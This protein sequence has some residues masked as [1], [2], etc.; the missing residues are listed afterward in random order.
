ML[1]HC[2]EVQDVA[3]GKP[4]VGTPWFV[5]LLAPFIRRTVVS[6]NPYPKGLRTHPQYVQAAV[7][8]FETERARLLVALEGFRAARHSPG[9]HPLFGDMTEA[10]RGWASYKH[11]DH[12][13]RQFGV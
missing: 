1:A 6:E 13:L 11:L 5:R 3:N 2:A 8:D 10:E 7:R 4:L 12:H 9:S